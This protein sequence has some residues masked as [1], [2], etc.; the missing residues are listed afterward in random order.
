MTN[1]KTI[2]HGDIPFHKIEKLPEGLTKSFEGNEY[3]A[4]EGETTGHMHRVKCAT[5]IEVYTDAWGNRFM[6]AGKDATISHEEHGTLTIPAGT[7]SIGKER[8]YDW[9]SNATRKVID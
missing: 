5:K 3:I 1:I 9:F 2:R 6:V 7:Y 8:E 4:A